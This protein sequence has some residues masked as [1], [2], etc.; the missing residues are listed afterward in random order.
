MTE[1][2]VGDIV[3]C[4]ATDGQPD[5]SFRTRWVRLGEK[6]TISMY[7]EF[8]GIVELVETGSAQFDAAIFQKSKEEIYLKKDGCDHIGAYER[9]FTT[10]SYM[11]CPKCKKEVV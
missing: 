11:H 4:L 10:F 8:F 1:F 7:N 5:V 2:N 9:K 6:Y 3:I